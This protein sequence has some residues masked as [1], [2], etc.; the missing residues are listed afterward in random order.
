MKT[1]WMKRAAVIVGACVLALAIAAEDS[2]P[3]AKADPAGDAAWKEVMLAL[4]PPPPPESWR[5]KEPTKEEVAAW[6]RKN[7]GLAGDAADKA[8]DFYTQ[9]SGHP[10]AQE[11][12][13]REIELLGVAVQ[14]GV[15]NRQA[16][17]EELQEKRLSDPSVP[18]AEKFDLRAQRVLR[19]LTADESDLNAAML[20]SAEK[21]T[22]SLQADFPDRD[23][24]F[25]L[26]MM[27]ARGYLDTG[28][29]SKAR[30]VTERLVAKSSDEVKEQ[31]EGLL[32]KLNL[33]GK[34]FE[35]QFTDVNG[36]AVAMKDYAGKVVLIDF[37]A[38]W[39]GPCRAA[40]PELKETYAKYHPKGFEIIGISFDKDKDA[41]T[42]FIADEKMTWPQY[43][44][45]LGWENKLGG[46]YGI[47]GIPTMWVVDKKGVLRDLNGERGLAAKLEKLLAEK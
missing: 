4:R 5:T 34:P 37:W 36:K 30:Q 3:A 27:I 28:D 11:A 41:L 8:R 38:T 43:F 19:L 24:V 46:K 17:F 16:R 2:K 12:R 29:L 9:H 18:A 20:G 6:E 25:E 14:L 44:D 26:Y 22:A 21:Q 47:Q 40:L 23:E 42:K 10:K 35:L 7:G 32:R 45:G 33:V 13:R 31:A 39:C 15:T 1:N